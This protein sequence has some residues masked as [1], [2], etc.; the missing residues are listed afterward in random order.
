MKKLLTLV[1]GALFAIGCGSTGGSSDV[2]NVGGIYKVTEGMR[3]VTDS[4][5]G[6]QQT[7]LAGLY[8]II[9]QNDDVVVLFDC[10]KKLKDNGDSSYTAKIGGCVSYGLDA[11]AGPGFFYTSGS[12]VFYEDTKVGVDVQINGS[13][14]WVDFEFTIDY[15]F[16]AELD[17][18]MMSDSCPSCG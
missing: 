7:D 2:P 14:P 8:L 10:G 6:T 3:E 13:Y 18:E 4:F 16:T 5:S 12:A 15:S 9:N 1:L 17:E 11:S